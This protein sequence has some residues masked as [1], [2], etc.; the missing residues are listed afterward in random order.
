MGII[1]ALHALGVA[2]IIELLCFLCLSIQ[3]LQLHHDLD[4]VKTLQIHLVAIIFV[5]RL[6]FHIVAL[7]LNGVDLLANLVDLL[8]QH[9]ALLLEML[10]LVLFCVPIFFL[11]LQL[12]H[13]SFKHSCQFPDFL[14]DIGK[15]FL[16]FLLASFPSLLLLVVQLIDL[17]FDQAG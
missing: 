17:F 2:I 4:A 11:V 8:C 14:F 13:L 3:L 16:F 12:A 7:L 1:T 5:Q 15:L 9:L 10:I 6:H